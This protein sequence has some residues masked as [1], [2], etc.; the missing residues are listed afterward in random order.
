MLISKWQGV[1]WNKEHNTPAK[2][3]TP[4]QTPAKKIL[5]P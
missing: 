4:E 5:D 2:S 1:T 3:F